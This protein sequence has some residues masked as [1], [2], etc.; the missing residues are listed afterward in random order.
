MFEKRS[1]LVPEFAKIVCVSMAF[2]LDNG[3]TKMQTFSGDDEYQL[4]IKKITKEAFISTHDYSA[5][6]FRMGG[7]PTY[8]NIIAIYKYNSF[9]VLEAEDIDENYEF[10]SEYVEKE[11]AQLDL[12][13]KQHPYFK[14]NK[15]NEYSIYEHIT[16]IRDKILHQFKTDDNLENI[17]SL[18]HKF[19][20]W[21][22]I[23][24]EKFSQS[25]K[26]FEN[27]SEIENLQLKINSLNSIIQNNPSKIIELGKHLD[28]LRKQ[29]KKI[30]KNKDLS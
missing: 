5:Y 18:I 15:Q 23:Q 17:V 8:N 20:S 29:H 6:H 14:K 22:E 1:A 4:L 10:D 7:K 27:S 24:I 12:A 28:K 2:V 25:K 9:S 11:I 3:E 30:T 13:L 21:N 26:Y 16:S 19:E